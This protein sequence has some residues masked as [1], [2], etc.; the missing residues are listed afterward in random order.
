ML[1]CQRAVLATKW[2]QCRLPACTSSMIPWG[3][4]VQVCTD[5]GL[6]RNAGALHAQVHAMCVPVQL[7]GALYQPWR[8]SL[9]AVQ[10]LR[11]TGSCSCSGS[12][13]RIDMPSRKLVAPTKR[14]YNAALEHSCAS[15]IATDALRLSHAAIN[16]TIT[17]R[18]RLTSSLNV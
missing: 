2:I 11:L 9:R 5:S 3:L 4:A 6:G 17:E 12:M 16:G 10:P 8:R 1:I 14:P 15:N 18:V 13:C 7:S